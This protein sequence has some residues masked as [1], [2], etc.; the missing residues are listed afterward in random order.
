MS[1]LINYL[2]GRFEDL[3]THRMT[4]EPTWDDICR[5]VQLSNTTIYDENPPG[6]N[7]EQLPN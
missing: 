4:F 6:D 1:D 7:N 2:I 3:Q 5:Y